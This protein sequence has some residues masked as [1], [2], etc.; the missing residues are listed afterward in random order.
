MFVSDDSQ[1]TTGEEEVREGKRT[2]RYDYIVPRKASAY[3]LRSG[4]DS[5]VVDYGGSFWVDPMTERVVALKVEVDQRRNNI[6][7]ALDMFDVKTMLEYNDTHMSG[8]ELPF[9]VSSTLTVVHFR[10]SIVTSNR[11]EFTGCRQYSA[12]SSVRFGDHG[13]VEPTAPAA[14]LPSELP[15]GLDLEVALDEPIRGASSSAGDVVSATL[16]RPVQAGMFRLPKGARLMGRILRVETDLDNDVTHVRVGFSQLETEDHYFPF[17][18]RFVTSEPAQ[19]VV[20]G[21]PLPAKWISLRD[22]RNAGAPD[23]ITMTDFRLMGKEGQMA[24][25]FRMKWTTISDQDSR[26]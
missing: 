16:R 2:I 8:E 26:R 18:A 9:P 5:A 20:K 12:E 21:G 15:G 24:K 13:T 4:T 3:V 14:K 10:T 1:F 25:G 17:R 6:P 7:E 22:I 19:G 23:W 11:I